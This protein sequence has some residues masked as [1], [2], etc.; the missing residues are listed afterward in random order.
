[1]TS[2]TATRPAAAVSAAQ[3]LAV[4]VAFLLGL[5]IIVHG[6]V[7]I[8]DAA[9]PLLLAVW[10]PNLSRYRGAWLLV[11]L[12]ALSVAWGWLLGGIAESDGYLLDGS[13]RLQTVSELAGVIAGAGVLLWARRIVPTAVLGSAFG[14]GLVGNALLFG[15]ETENPWK[16]VWGL[17][18]SV[19]VL[20]LVALSPRSARRVPV[21]A[22]ILVL[23][24]VSAALDCRSYAAALLLTLVLYLAA[25]RTTASARDLPSGLVAG[26]VVALA[27]AMYYL[28]QTL[29]V[30]GVLGEAT[31]ARTLE[32][33]D[34]S[35][36][37]I[38]GG[39][40]ELGATWSLLQ[41]RPI[42]F[43]A[44]VVPQSR[45]IMVGKTGLR[46]TD[47]AISTDYVEKYMFGG[48]IELHS[49]F[50]D[51]WAAFGIPG[52]LLAVLVAA[53]TLRGV[54][55]FLAARTGSATA[56]LACVWTLWNVGFSPFTSS[57]AIMML[58]LALALPVKRKRQPLSSSE[59]RSDP[60]A[61]ASPSVPGASPAVR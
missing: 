41:Y 10:V 1:M 48:R 4:L 18:V 9:A 54:A 33:I 59:R 31:R 12:G 47:D 24:V 46:A 5:Q 27:G 45:D 21:A 40:P 55:H 50:G 32:Q 2:A 49:V 19:L 44:G 8:G 35:G 20:S 23:T 36:S 39:R 25:T 14:L 6:G 17:P 42:G 7:T 3:L 38:L 58:G 28:G 22:T 30:S 57:S 56:I 34:T 15:P 61:A 13:I 26:F 60:A 29:L 51:F 52:L 53:L 37:L 16:Y 11:V 43:G